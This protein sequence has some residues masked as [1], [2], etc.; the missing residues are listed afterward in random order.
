M[1]VV[2]ESGQA[3]GQSLELHG[4]VG[5]SG[6]QRRGRVL[7]EAAGQLQLVGAELAFARRLDEEQHAQRLVAEDE[8]DVQMSELADGL[9]GA[10]H[11]AS[12]RR[13]R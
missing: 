10:P 9:H 6:V 11:R 8:G 3:V 4:L 13:G 1:T 12:V 2:E 7:S 5:A